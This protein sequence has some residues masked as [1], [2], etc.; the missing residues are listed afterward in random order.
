MCLTMDTIWTMRRVLL[1]LKTPLPNQDSWR[2]GCMRKFLAEKYKA[3][4]L[5]HDTNI[6]EALIDSI[7]KT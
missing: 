2:I 7:C 6:L 3:E 5:E 4:A 1:D